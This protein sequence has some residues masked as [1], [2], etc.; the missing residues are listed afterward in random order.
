MPRT[1]GPV[2]VAMT[3]LTQSFTPAWTSSG[4]PSFVNNG[5]LTGL[6]SLDGRRLTF[7]IAFTIGST[8]AFGTGVWQ[9]TLPYTPAAIYQVVT[10]RAYDSSAN[11]DYILAASVLPSD[12]RV[13]PFAT[14]T[15]LSQLTLSSPFTW[16][17]GDQLHVSGTILVA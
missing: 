7:A 9:F 10:G 14:T 12:A 11:G 4:T 2:N 16:A 15:A 13:G 6:Y 3:D 5:T 1:A 8:T 17:T